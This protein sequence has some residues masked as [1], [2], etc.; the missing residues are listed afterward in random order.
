M[1]KT[2]ADQIIE[3]NQKKYYHDFNQ[4]KFMIGINPGRHG[5]GVTGVP[6]TDTKR[7]ESVCGIKMESAHTHEIIFVYFSNSLF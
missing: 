7:L 5:A 4:R 1:I 3:F 2:F 6:F